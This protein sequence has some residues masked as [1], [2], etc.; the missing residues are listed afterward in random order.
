MRRSSVVEE[1]GGE[2][3]EVATPG[4]SNPT[5]R[6]SAPDGLALR[7]HASDVRPTTGE[8]VAFTV[9]WRDGSGLYAGMTQDWGD[10]SPRSGSI[11]P[12]ACSG[13]ASPTAGAQV[14]NH[15][16]NGAG[17]YATVISVSTTTCDGQVE[18]RSVTLTIVVSAPPQPSPST[19]PSSEPSPERPA[20]QAGGAAPGERHPG[21]AASGDASRRGSPGERHPGGAAPGE[22]TPGGAASGEASLRSAFPSM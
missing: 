22:R 1:G 21:G 12:R 13:Q 6:L 7:V 16:F 4:K 3:H 14:V 19:Q 9:S 15:T 20:T 17:T 8:S 2:L 18:T 10:G 11:N 5:T